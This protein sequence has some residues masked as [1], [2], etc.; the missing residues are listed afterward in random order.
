ML[1]YQFTCS[2]AAE[3]IGRTTRQLK[4]RIK[5]HHP[6]WLRSGDQK[7]IR[8]AIVAH[9]ADSGHTINPDES[10]R[11]IYKAPYNAP[12]SIQTRLISTAE[13][14][15]IR[16]HD[17]VLCRQKLFVQAL[18]LPWPHK[19]ERTA[20]ASFPQTNIDIIDPF[21]PFIRPNV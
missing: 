12:R 20:R 3:Y 11:I 18:Q 1:V 21:P 13:A 4:V 8:S 16:L 9:L 14:V 7:S 17:P 19:A 15:A 10:F 2:C 5:E 6:A